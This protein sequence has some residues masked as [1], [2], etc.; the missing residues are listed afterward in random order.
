MPIFDQGYQHWHGR[1]SGHAWRWLAIT[2]RGVAV[3]WKGRGVKWVVASALGPAL[4]LAGFLIVWGLFEQQSPK[5]EEQSPTFQMIFRVLQLPEE[6]K[7]GP[8][9]YRDGL[10]DAGLPL[11]LRRRDVLLDDPGR[12]WSAPT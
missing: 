3:Q 7:A 11:L 9:G 5:P 12:C 4:L 2:R 1:L 6:L 8:K 10:L